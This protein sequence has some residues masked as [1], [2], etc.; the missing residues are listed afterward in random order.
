MKEWILAVVSFVVPG[1]CW[2]AYQHP[3]AYRQLAKTICKLFGWAFVGWIAFF[4]A[5]D[6]YV[7]FAEPAVG[8]ET[9]AKVKAAAKSQ[10]EFPGWVF[11]IIGAIGAYGYFLWE[12]VGNLKRPKKR[13][14]VTEPKQST[15]KQPTLSN[16]APE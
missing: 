15:G 10:S 7:D 2:L 12:F 5:G 11:W 9:V 1:S 6:I 4:I 14:D 16:R 8:K 3:H 13:E